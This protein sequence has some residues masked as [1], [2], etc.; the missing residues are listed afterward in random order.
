ML[1]QN[2]RHARNL[3]FSRHELLR[4]LMGLEAIECEQILIKKSSAKAPARYLFIVKS[5]PCCDKV[6]REFFGLTR[7]REALEELQ[8]DFRRNKGLW[9]PEMADPEEGDCQVNVSASVAWNTMAVSVPEILDYARDDEREAVLAQMKKLS[10]SSVKLCRKA[11]KAYRVAV[12]N[13]TDGRRVSSLHEFAVILGDSIPLNLPANRVRAKRSDAWR[14]VE[15]PLFLFSGIRDRV[16]LV[17]PDI[18]E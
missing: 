10:C 7:L 1:D 15:E 18:P 13:D 8:V 14:G 12:R 2:H 5:E 11:G 9:V 17:Y 16:W 6:R 4:Y 3:I